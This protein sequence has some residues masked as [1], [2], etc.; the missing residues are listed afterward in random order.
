MMTTREIRAV[1]RAAG[2]APVERD[3]LYNLIAN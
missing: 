1:I 2:R 3:T